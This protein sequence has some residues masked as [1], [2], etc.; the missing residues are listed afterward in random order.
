[1]PME[2]S[3]PPEGTSRNEQ[4][5]PRWLTSG[6]LFVAVLLFVVFAATMPPD[7][8]VLLNGGRIIFG[9]GL[10]GYCVLLWIVGEQPLGL[11]LVSLV[12]SASIIASAFL[13]IFVLERGYHR[14]FSTVN[15]MIF[16]VFII[17]FSVLYRRQ[18]QNG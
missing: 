5:I 16:I 18:W 12:P 10:I 4:R 7:A 2:R 3:G 15:T 14:T 9:W 8:E 13:D 17:W 1:M 6:P 11:T